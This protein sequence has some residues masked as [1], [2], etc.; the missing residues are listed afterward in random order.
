VVAIAEPRS[1]TSVAI[2]TPGRPRTTSVRFEYWKKRGSD[3]SASNRD[4]A[5]GCGEEIEE[6][7]LRLD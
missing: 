4:F 7:I 2:E 1:R 5:A 6:T 3:A